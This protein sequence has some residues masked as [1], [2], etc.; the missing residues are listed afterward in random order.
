MNLCCSPDVI[1]F[2]VRGWC[3]RF[4][5][6]LILIFT[7]SLQCF[8]RFSAKI[9]VEVFAEL[10]FLAS[11]TNIG[12]IAV[13]QINALIGTI[14]AAVSKIW[15]SFTALF[16]AGGPVGVICAATIALLGVACISTIVA[17]IVYGYL[18]KGFAIGWKT[19]TIFPW[20]WEWY[21]GEVI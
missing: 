16:T 11:T 15:F 12:A 7:V 17:M 6:S 9:I 8:S 2:K 21:C 18:G 4:L 3:K 13:T 19:P 20:T 10:S 1:S 14:T 5:F